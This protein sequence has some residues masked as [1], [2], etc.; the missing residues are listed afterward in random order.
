MNV[1]D[2]GIV[3][4]VSEKQDCDKQMQYKSQDDTLFW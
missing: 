4:Y 3:R 2:E 1:N